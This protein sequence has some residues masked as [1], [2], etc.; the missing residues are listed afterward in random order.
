MRVQGQELSCKL[1]SALYSCDEER[2]MPWFT[3]LC[4]NA[5]GRSGR[6]FL[7]ARAA[8]EGLAAANG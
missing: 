7:P 3:A 2:S 4:F 8:G 5:C 6:F 1:S